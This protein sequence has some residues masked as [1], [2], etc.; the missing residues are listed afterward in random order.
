LKK[1]CVVTGTRAE[2]G[3]LRWIM[4]AIQNDHRLQFQLIVTGMHLSPEFGLTYKEIEDDGFVID[5]KIEILTSSDTPA[6]IAKAMGLG[7]IGFADALTDLNPDLLILL[8][9]RFEILS[10]A[11]AATIARI[12]IAHLHGGEK[13]E[14]AIDE[15]FRHAITKMSH[16]HFVATEEY[17][18]RVIQL[19]ENP[20]NVFTVGGFGLD[21]IKRL[22]LLSREKI[23]EILKFKFYKKNL[24]VTFHPVTLENSTAKLQMLELIKVLSELKDTRIIFTY[25]NSDTDGRQIIQMID[26]FVLEHDNAIAFINL[27]QLKFFSCIQFIDGVIGNSSSGL[28]EIPSFRKGTVNIGDRQKGRIQAGSVIQCEPTYVSIKNAVTK[29]Y[30]E[31]FQSSLSQVENPYS[32]GGAT[33]KTM[34]ILKNISMSNIVKKQFYDLNIK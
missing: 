2:Y 17:R 4:S 20:D 27:G 32:D 24:L 15:S 25:P 9:D 13:T 10:A 16:F 11:T 18:N 28:I 8:G 12:P 23:E 1:I 6:G 19:G 31:S 7:L 21:S 3:L 14:G 26:S 22:Q 29:L 5:K 33:E 34:N 30:S